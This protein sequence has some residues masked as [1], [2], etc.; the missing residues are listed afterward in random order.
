MCTKNKIFTLIAALFVI[1]VI[2]VKAQDNLA[3]CA[4]TIGEDV[5]YLKDFQVE[6]GPQKAG[7]PIPSSKFSLMLNKNTVYKFNICNNAGSQGHAIIQLMDIN[8]LIASSYNE[9]TKKE[10]SGFEFNCT[11]TGVYHVFIS[12]V[13]GKS[14]S[15][16]AIISFVKK[17]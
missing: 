14:G 10:Y 13:E 6:L 8:K 11:K 7:Q 9:S 17:L 4:A 16:T 12:F 15:A 1:S 3:L 2:S 5:T